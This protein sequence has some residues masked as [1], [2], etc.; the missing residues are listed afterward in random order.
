MKKRLFM[1]DYREGEQSMHKCVEVIQQGKE[2]PDAEIVTT[3]HAFVGIFTA[4]DCVMEVYADMTPGELE[5]ISRHP[6][7]L[8]LP[9]RPLYVNVEEAKRVGKKIKEGFPV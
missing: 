7:S 2:I 3:L 9:R 1:V 5:A 6:A 4:L 8:L